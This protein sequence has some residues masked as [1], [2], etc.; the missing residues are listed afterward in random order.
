[1]GKLIGTGQDPR[2][3]KGADYDVHD[4]DVEAH[5]EAGLGVPVD[6][7]TERHKIHRAGDR[8]IEY[9]TDD[10]AVIG[11]GPYE[12]DGHV[13]RTAARVDKTRLGTGADLDDGDPDAVREDEVA[14][15][16]TDED[17]G[18]EGDGKLTGQALHD[19]AAELNI[20]GRGSMN[21]D[22]LR[23]AVAKA[24]AEQE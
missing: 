21:A 4:D 19:R 1:M 5:A 13:N 18:D 24:E 12:R 6:A 7:D 8:I 23:D 17:D 15:A 14:H 10:D 2:M 22:E 9:D 11:R 20:E 3:M 16:P